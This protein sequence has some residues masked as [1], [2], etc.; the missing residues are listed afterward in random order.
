MSKV[1][2]YGGEN[3][4]DVMLESVV[5][6]E[7]FTLV[8]FFA[9]WCG[10][11]KSL[12][13]VLEELSEEVN[14]SIIKIDVDQYTDLAAFYGVRS[15]PTTIIFK[16]GKPVETLIGGRSKETLVKEMQ[17]IMSK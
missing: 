8:N 10:P 1:I 5:A 12:A 4:V 17:E 14:Y 2:Y 16:D 3:K 9:T 7:G 6:K 15:I 13:P 11:C